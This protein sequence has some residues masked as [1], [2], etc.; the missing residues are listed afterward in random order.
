MLLVSS[1]EGSTFQLQLPL[2]GASGASSSETL[3]TQPVRDEALIVWKG[4][5]PWYDDVT[6]NKFYGSDPA[7]KAVD[8][9]VPKLLALKEALAD[10]DDWG[11]LRGK[12]K[13]AQSFYNKYVDVIEKEDHSKNVQAEASKKAA[14]AMKKIDDDIAAARSWGENAFKTAIGAAV[15]KKT[16]QFS[17]TGQ[18]TPS[19]I[20][21]KYT[22]SVVK[23]AIAEWNQQGFGIVTCWVPGG[24]RP[25]NKRGHS[26]A[27]ATTEAN[28]MSLWTGGA[29]GEV[30]VHVTI[31]EAD[32]RSLG[33][34]PESPLNINATINL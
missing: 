16:L 9:A 18:K 14:S 11:P 8:A 10:K 34:D 19:S 25:Q 23:A 26:P 22:L 3:V 28:F 27:R 32:L 1:H 5:E 4:L 29:G 6:I 33:Y 20:S 31:D 24:G 17:R 30:N 12:V 7:Q 15:W 13:S 2:L 21:G